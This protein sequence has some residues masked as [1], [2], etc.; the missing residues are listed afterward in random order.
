[1]N[2]VRL[3]RPAPPQCPAKPGSGQTSAIS[4][5]LELQQHPLSPC[6]LA[7]A[8]AS[9]S[10][11]ICLTALSVAPGQRTPSRYLQN[12]P[13]TNQHCSPHS[14]KPPP[15]SSGEPAR[16]LAPSSSQSSHPKSLLRRHA[17]PQLSIMDHLASVLLAFP[18]DVGFDTA[19]NEEYD[20]TIRAHVSRVNKLLKEKSSS[21]VAHSSTLIKVRSSS[22]CLACAWLLFPILP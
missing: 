7:C 19:S 3:Q 5:H 14:Y 9:C 8:P 1:M 11:R 20:K 21:L 16:L 2:T 10:Q 12:L 15:L 18:P 13:L 22:F 17:P 6:L 4:V